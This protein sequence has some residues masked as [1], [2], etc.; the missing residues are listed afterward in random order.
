LLTFTVEAIGGIIIFFSIA[1]KDFSNV[2]DRLFFSLF[3]AISGF[4][5]AGFSTLSSS[6]YDF[7][8]RY[9]YSLHMTIAALFII[10]GLGFPIIFNF[11]KYLKYLAGRWIV[12]I[13]QR[14]KAIIKPWVININTRI[15]LI[16]TL[17]LIVSGTTLFYIFEFDN[18]LDEHHGFDKIVTAFFGAVTP[19]TAGFNT[20]D[21]SALNFST[22][23][24]IFL[25][26]WI[27]AS[28][29]STGGGIKTSAF[30][31]ATLNY[32]SLA[33]GKDRLEVYGRE[34]ASNSI[35]RAFAFIALSLV[36]IG[37][38]VFLIA[39]FDSDKDLLH[40]AFECFSAYSTVGLSLSQTGEFS[41]ASKLVIICT[42][43]IGRVSML[44][45]LIALF[46]RVHHLKYRYP[47]EE[48]LI[49]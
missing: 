35:R 22:I 25:L 13:S 36:V 21:T 44:T 15:V 20:V 27:G 43:F 47:T 23:M 16:T 46:R 1:N 18:T 33:R 12:A 45:L 41:S 14:E 40:I 8:F 19:R 49:N 6:F 4:C 32:L 29:A 38:S 2:A 9:N 37:I 42:M 11:F 39:F 3:H 30:A 10:G 34:I 7:D 17:I 5:N 24:I 28:P 48:I 26:M 31:I